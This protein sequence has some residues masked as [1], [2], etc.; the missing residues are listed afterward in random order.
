MKKLLCLLYI[1]SLFAFFPSTHVHAL[2]NQVS[3]PE[4]VQASFQSN[5]GKTTIEV[6]AKI[7]VPDTKQMFLIPVKSAFFP[8]D[9]VQRVFTALWP[10]E[11]SPKFEEE[12]EDISLFTEGKGQSDVFTKHS[13]SMYARK[14]NSYRAVHSRYYQM[15]NSNSPYDVALNTNC[16]VQNT[17]LYDGYG[18]NQDVPKEGIKGHALTTVQAIEKSNSFLHAL[19]KQP[20]TFFNIGAINGYYFDGTK[21]NAC[22]YQSASPSYTLT[23]TRMVEGAPLL[24]AYGQ[25]MDSSCRDDLYIPAVGYDQ[26]FITFNQEGEISNFCWFCPTEI[27][28]ERFPQTLLPFSKIM[29]I[30]EKILP[31]RYQSLEIEAP[32]HYTVQDIVLGYMALLQRDQLSFALTP[33][34]NFYGYRTEFIDDYAYECYLPLLSINAIDGTVIDLAYGY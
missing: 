9:L 20:Y 28:E 4:S 30:A 21:E 31:L 23:Y 8:E 19:T 16:R 27:M 22:S 34:W 5:T 11:K 1:L 12:T 2:Q 14:K 25:M 26:M 10:N 18:R 15:P 6:D 32:Q 29:P 17:I 7:Y 13:T 24:P 33:V 3:A